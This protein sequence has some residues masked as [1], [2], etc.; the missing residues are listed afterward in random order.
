MVSVCALP[1]VVPVLLTNLWSPFIKWAVQDPNV[2]Y[3]LY[4]DS[5]DWLVFSSINV[6]N[7]RWHKGHEHYFFCYICTRSNK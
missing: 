2:P 1:E 5:A 7:Y 3:G 4:V 6:R